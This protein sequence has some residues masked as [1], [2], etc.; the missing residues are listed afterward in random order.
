MAAPKILAID[1][2]NSCTNLGVFEGSALIA[3][4]FF[5]SS[6][7]YADKIRL[8]VEDWQKERPFER[9][10]ISSVAPA[11]GDLLVTIIEEQTEKKPI[12]VEACKTQLLPLLV[13]RPETVGVDRIVNCCAAIHYY[14][15]PAIVVSLGTATTFEAISA[16]GEY[17]GGAIAPGV[18]ISLEALTQRTAL[19][20]PVIWKKPKQIIAKNTIGHMESGIYYGTIS[21]IE[22]MAK[23]IKAVLGEKTAV[24]GTGGIS[25]L[26]AD[27]NVFDY[28][29][30]F[31]TL[32]GLELIYRR[33]CGHE[34]SAMIPPFQE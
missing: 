13:D 3:K 33:L 14:G 19:L 11:L 23:R 4:D 32:R 17:L 8:R 26:L 29:D 15:A 10:V 18:K 12:M 27:E 24:I 7:E 31:L 34:S 21:L 6:P 20:P 22:G 25:A 9:A 30:P 16:Q 5:P 1:I 28:Y 2:G